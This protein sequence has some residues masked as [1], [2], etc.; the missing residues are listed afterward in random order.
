[1]QLTNI[2]RDITEDAQMGRIYLPLEW[3]EEAKIPLAEITAPEYRERLAAV[4]IRL[5]READRFYRSADAGLW[6]LSFR[7]ACAVS[8]ARHVYAEIGH[9][10]LRKGS[11][12]WDQRTYVTG[13]RKIWVVMRGIVALTTSVPERLSRPWSPA[14]IRIVWNYSKVQ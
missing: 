13:W 5:L 2:A 8:A 11:R 1:M 7:S 14:P 12:A 6:H 10:L 9:L 3:L 4:T